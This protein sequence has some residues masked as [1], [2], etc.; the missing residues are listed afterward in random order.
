[1]SMKNW[2]PDLRKPQQLG[3]VGLGIRSLFSVFVFWWMA[4]RLVFFVIFLLPAFLR[5]GW[6]YLFNKNIHKSLKYGDRFRQNLDVYIPNSMKL[7]S[8]DKIS[9]KKNLI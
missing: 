2:K 3:V 9:K 5:I 7:Y 1:M 6:W 8:N 4:I